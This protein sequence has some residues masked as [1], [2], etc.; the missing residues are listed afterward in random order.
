MNFEKSENRLP[1][2]DSTYKAC[3]PCNTYN[4]CKMC[5]TYIYDTIISPYRSTHFLHN[6]IQLTRNEV[7]RIS[8]TFSR[9]LCNYRNPCFFEEFEGFTS[10]EYCNEWAWAKFNSENPAGIAELLFEIQEVMYFS[11]KKKGVTEIIVIRFFMDKLRI[12]L[13]QLPD[14]HR[15]HTEKM[16]EIQRSLGPVPFTKL[17]EIRIKA[18]LPRPKLEDYYKEELY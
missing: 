5:H 8:N 10:V 1:K 16:F 4:P 2:M 3:K 12:L 6:C 7:L 18:N 14:I 13:I 17:L 15:E 9:I 11:K